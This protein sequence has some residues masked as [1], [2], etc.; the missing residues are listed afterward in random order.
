ML[1]SEHILHETPSLELL[2]F[3][4]AIDNTIRSSFVACPQKFF[5]SHINKLSP[6]GT[7]VHLHAGAAFASGIEATQAVNLVVKGLEG[8]A[9]AF[10]TAEVAQLAKKIAGA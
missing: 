4:E 6:Q 10:K 3:P 5:Y 9:A 7:N 2:S 8:G 1:P